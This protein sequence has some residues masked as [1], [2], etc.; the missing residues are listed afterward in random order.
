[1]CC[2]CCEWRQVVTAAKK[3]HPEWRSTVLGPA[4]NGSESL[5]LLRTNHLNWADTRF[6]PDLVLLSAASKDPSP[7]HS[8]GYWEVAIAAIEEATLLPPTCK[9]V[10]MLTMNAVLRTSE[11]EPDE[12]SEE[13]DSSAVTLSISVAHLPDST[14]EMAEF[15]RKDLRRC[16]RGVELDNPFTAIEDIPSFML[17]GVND[18]SA[19]QLVPVVEEW[20]PG[21]AVV[22][23]VSPL[24]DR[25]IPLVTYSGTGNRQD[26]KPRK[27]RGAKQSSQRASSCRPRPQG[28]ISFPSTMLLR[29]HGNVGIRSFSSSGYYP[30][31]PVIRC[32]RASVVDEL[33]QV[34]TYD[35]VS[36]L[37]RDASEE[38]ALHLIMNLLEP[39]E[40]FA[41]EQ[42][43][44]GLN[45]FSCTNSEPL[46]HLLACCN[47]NKIKQSQ[48]TSMPI[49]RL[50]FVFWLQNGLMSLPGLC[51]QQGAYGILAAHHPTRT[52]HALAKALQSTQT[53]LSSRSE[54]EFGAFVVA[55]ALNEVEDPV[56]AKEISQL[57]I[58]VFKELQIGGCIVSS[59]IGPVAFPGGI[60]PPVDR[61]TTQVQ[62]HTTCG[63]VFYTKA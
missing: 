25:C 52:S 6:A 23:A 42:E 29:L 45:I 51:W 17:F 61:N 5:E 49:D 13:R 26:R 56:Y 46:E 27:N 2:V 38:L 31:T 18:Q 15:D 12:E 43:G 32:E 21:A 47:S 48:S 33:S 14:M 16:Q 39:S 41:I 7:W 22:G 57:C 20:Y 28:E 50:E 44:R 54:R 59:S 40:R 3:V 24:I 53:D 62:T 1:M 11:D 4:S 30:I 60:Q 55:G 35:L 8:G 37:N 36:K 58:D 19:S 34:V 10:G 63:A 9:I